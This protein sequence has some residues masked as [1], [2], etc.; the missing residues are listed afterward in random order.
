MTESPVGLCY[1]V[2]FGNFKKK[3]IFPVLS[4]RLSSFSLA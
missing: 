2:L 3:K 4:L 1:S